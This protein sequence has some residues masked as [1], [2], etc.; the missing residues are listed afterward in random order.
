MKTTELLSE[1]TLLECLTSTSYTHPPV[2]IPVHQA[3]F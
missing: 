1:T 3:K 2:F